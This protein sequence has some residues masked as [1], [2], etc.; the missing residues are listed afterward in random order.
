MTTDHDN[1]AKIIF[2]KK[3]VCVDE[4]CAKFRMG[5]NNIT[6]VISIMYC[7]P[8]VAY[9]T[10]TWFN[11]DENYNKCWVSSKSNNCLSF[12]EAVKLG[13]EF[14]MSKYFEIVILIGFIYNVLLVISMISAW[15]L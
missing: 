12:D 11:P 2:D 1:N 3:I 9:T 5:M 14:N 13:G 8:L 4:T 10:F 15:W 7:I 6:K